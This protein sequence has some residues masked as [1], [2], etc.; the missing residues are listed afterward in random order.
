MRPL[1]DL[2]PSKAD[3]FDYWKNKLDLKDIFI[4]W[5]EPSCWACKWGWDG[6]Y[7]I[8]HPDESWEKIL[9]AWEKAPLQ[10]CHILPRSLGGSDDVS[11]LFLMCRECHDLAPNTTNMDFFFF[12]A[13]K[14]N[15][16]RRAST[17]IKTEMELLE[18]N[19]EQIN[20]LNN[21]LVTQDFQTWLS[22][23]VGIHFPQSKYSSIYSRITP[24]SMLGALLKYI[25][26]NPELG[27]DISIDYYER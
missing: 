14:Q 26:D 2:L 9:R 16:C 1:N 24:S 11:N 22:G 15:W 13:R 23:N 25:Q 3:I 17:R 6:R 18:I 27:V 20:Q 12:W 21:I 4:D 19:K 7:D 5:G 10:R 8:R